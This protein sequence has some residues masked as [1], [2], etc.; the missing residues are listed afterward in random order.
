MQTDLLPPG[1][2]FIRVKARD[3]SGNEQYAF[4]YYVTE[5]GKEYG[6]KCFYI[7]PDGTIAEDVYEE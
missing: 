4:D 7:L 1:Q 3:S 5:Q 2:Y 6:I